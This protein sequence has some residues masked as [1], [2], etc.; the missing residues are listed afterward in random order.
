V[1]IHPFLSAPAFDPETI[2]TMSEAL[3]GVCE[4]LDLQLADGPEACLVAQK[5][6]ELAQRGVRDAVTLRAMTLK[7]FKYE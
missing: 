2:E 7:E 5:I 1:T 4:T 3:R 6:I